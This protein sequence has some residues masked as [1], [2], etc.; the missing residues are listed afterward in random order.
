MLQ[1]IRDKATGWIAYLIIIGISIPFALWGI[2]QYFTASP[3]VVAEVNGQKISQ[4]SFYNVYQER[5]KNIKESISKNKEESDLQEK[6]IKRTVL[7]DLIDT[8][9]VDK[10]TT[11]NNFKVTEQALIKDIQKNDIFKEDGKFRYE[12]YENILK[13]QGIKTS[14]YE[15]IRKNELK[16]LQFFNS[17]VLTSLISKT[18]LEYLKNLKYQKRSFKTFSLS[19]KDFTKKRE[20]ISEKDK[21]EF[22]EKRKEF[23]QHPQKINIEY[24]IFNEDTIKSKVS[25][26][27][28]ELKRYY[29][30]N[31]LIYTTP[32]SRKLSQIFIKEDS[33]DFESEESNGISK[34]LDLANSIK[35]R[36]DNGENFGLL[37]SKYSDDKLSKDKK[38]N[39]G[40]IR[41]RD[42][43]EKLGSLI[44]SLDINEVSDVIETDNGYYIF[45]ALNEKKKVIKSFSSVKKEIYKKYSNEKNQNN[46]DSTI[47]EIANLSFESPDTLLPIANL[48]GISTRSTGLK[49]ISFL[50]KK[51][52]FLKDINVSNAVFSKPIYE[53]NLNSDILPIKN[54]N[55]LI[56][57]IREK[58]KITYKNLKE[59]Q[60][61]IEGLIRIEN[62]MMSMTKSLDDIKTKIKS[63]SGF[64]DMAVSYGKRVKFYKNIGR[65]NSEINSRLSET[66]F[67]LSEKTPIAAVESST[68]IYDIVYLTDIIDGDSDLSEESLNV[69]L[70][71]ELSNK[72]L[73]A[74]IQHLRKESDIE[75]FLENLE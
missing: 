60:Q 62:S 53:D 25:I 40:W 23:F 54:G 41:K 46:F 8:L 26:T 51:N 4:T 14:E 15:R 19:Y 24:L 2:D 3:T 65:D 7:D 67:S 12:R 47:E 74:I 17:I 58:S 31:I 13:R 29:H 20:K 48:L 5:Y 10:F 27:E 66:V 61:E 42:L 56:F 59:V 73:Y 63:G 32:T 18:Q 45:K 16:S 21:K 11:E 75:I 55:F 37:A 50:K 30:D 38:G 36:I 33:G 43:D 52:L 9:I 71:N 22:Y 6:I 72:E 69:M 49:T 44:F 70:S 39:I 68:G 1:N 28:D 35:K 64:D 57:R 34:K